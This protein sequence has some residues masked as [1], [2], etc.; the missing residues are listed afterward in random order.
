MVIKCLGSLAF[1]WQRKKHRE[2]G[3]LHQPSVKLWFPLCSTG[4]WLKPFL[5][6]EGQGAEVKGQWRAGP[7]CVSQPLSCSLL[8]ASW[9]VATSF[10]AKQRH[11]FI[12]G[13]FFFS[14]PTLFCCHFNSKVCSMVLTCFPLWWQIGDQFLDDWI[15]QALLWYSGHLQPTL[16]LAMHKQSSCLLPWPELTLTSLSM[17]CYTL[18]P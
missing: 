14:Q 2:P 3:F 12:P 4:H 13:C 8:P 17:S 18:S 1:Y 6:Q 7:S 9:V 11:N 16:S 5:R 10:W 15:Y